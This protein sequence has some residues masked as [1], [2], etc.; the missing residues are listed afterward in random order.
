MKPKKILIIDDSITNNL[1]YETIF[2]DNGHSVII[3][4]N[5]RDGL[6]LAFRENPEIIIL[7]IMMPDISGFSVLETLK[8]DPSTK[9]I[10]VIMISAKQ[11]R[12]SIEKSLALGASDYLTKPIE[13]HLLLQ[14]V[15]KLFVQK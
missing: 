2:E 8:K 12:A 13:I 15:E 3:A 14:R 5:G 6:D 10:P 11:D 1:L 9:E 4:E 7:D